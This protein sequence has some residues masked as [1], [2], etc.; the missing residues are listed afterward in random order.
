MHAFM[1]P[2]GH[3]SHSAA[4]E[5]GRP[6]G[7]CGN[8]Y[9]QLLTTEQLATHRRL[10][11]SFGDATHASLRPFDLPTGYVMVTYGT[12]FTAGIASNGDASS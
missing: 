10:T 1:C 11:D 2:K 12:G 8:E 9:S 6:C 5:E 3:V 7:T 4:A